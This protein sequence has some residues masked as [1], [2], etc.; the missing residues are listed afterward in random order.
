MSEP[1]RYCCPHCGSHWY[2]VR[3]R[4][5]P[6]YICRGCGEEFDEPHDKKTDG[7]ISA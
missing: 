1:W 2:G 4:T 7:V 6:Q 5:D 3:T